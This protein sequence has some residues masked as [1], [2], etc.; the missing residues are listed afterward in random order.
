MYDNPYGS[1]IET[2][3]LA[4]TPMELIEILFD[5]AVESVME[6]R[7]H[8]AE[9]RIAER[10]RAVTKA[11][12]ILNELSRSL[13]HSA[14]GELSARLASLY[15][16]IAQRLLDANFRQAD[17]G[18]AEAE[19]LLRTLLEGW[20]GAVAN[21]APPPSSCAPVYAGAQQWSA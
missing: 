14:G 4:A 1:S 15:D 2:R 7:R 10:G 11:V 18:M 5:A 3:V 20:S 13:D 8:L 21:Q 17:D 9:G 6:A 12:E 16:Y 19:S